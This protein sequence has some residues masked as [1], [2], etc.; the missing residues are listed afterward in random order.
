MKKKIK[1]HVADDH[2]ILIEG[3][4]AMLNTDKEIKVV[5]YSLTGLRVLEWFETNNADV[6]VLDINMPELD[7]IEVLKRFNKKKGHQKIIMLSSYDDVKLVKELITF[8]ADGFISKTS[9]GEHIIKAIKSVYDNEPYFSDDIKKGLFNLAIGHNVVDGSRPE[10]TATSSL[11]DRELEVLKLV[12]QEYST[13]EMADQ[14]LLSVNTV[15]TYR[16]NLLK[17]L[18][19]KNAVGLAMYAVK[20]RII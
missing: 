17:K 12:T 6:L 5:G 14:L 1:V 9:A 13:Q 20:H 10:P 4:I 3:I 2:M 19:V 7:G 16:K 18:N 15:E 11:T 8:G